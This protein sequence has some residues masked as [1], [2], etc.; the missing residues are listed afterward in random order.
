MRFLILKDKD[1]SAKQMNELEKEFSDF[2]FA[3]TGILPTFFIEERDYTTIPLTTDN[4]GDFKPTTSYMNGLTKTVHDKY[5]DYGVDS[6][7]MLV[8]RD[9]WTF[10][11][12]WGTNFSNVYYKYHV[13]LCRFDSK[14]VANSLGTL[15]HEWM[16]SLDALI[17]THTGKEIDT[18]FA[19]ETCFHDWDTTCVHGNR[20]VS[21]SATEYTY[22]KWKDNT[23]ALK[24]ITPLLKQAYQV[25]KDLHFAPLTNLQ[26]YFISWMRA[27]INKKNGVNKSVQ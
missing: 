20:T 1:I 22:I 3:N 9:N 23:K 16:H 11:G 8:H 24:K 2:I 7:V 4:D 15:Y 10:D 18:L 27:F 6:V 13:H 19:G 21:C 14:N 26:K 17:A 5:G 12:I 25:R